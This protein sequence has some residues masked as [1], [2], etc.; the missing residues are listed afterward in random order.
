MTRKE[1]KDLRQR[2]TTRQLMGVQQI[3]PHGII[4]SGGAL[5]FFLI[6]PDNLSVL[7][8]EGIR[9][10]VKA[11]GDLFRSESELAILALDSRESFQ[12]NKDFYQGRL[13]REESIPSIRALLARD[14]AHLDEIQA[15]YATAREFVLILRSGEREGADENSLRQKEKG[16]RDHGIQVRLAEEQDVKRLLSVYYQRDMT[17]DY[18]VSVDGEMEVVKCDK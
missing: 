2:Q 11:L 14:M 17:T 3:T 10:R 13:E 18:F 1:K 4:T 15:E 8:V 9:A 16:L 6:H 5:T 12:H 7:S